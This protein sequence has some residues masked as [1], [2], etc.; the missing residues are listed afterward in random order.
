MA[1][2]NAESLR[3]LVREGN[4]TELRAA[5]LSRYEIRRQVL[6]EIRRRT[7]EIAPSREMFSTNWAGAGLMSRYAI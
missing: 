1:K 7:G 6:P 5:G 4:W 3:T 2:F